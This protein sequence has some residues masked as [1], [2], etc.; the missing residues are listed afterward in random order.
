MKPSPLRKAARFAVIGLIALGILAHY[1]GVSY[2]N[3]IPDGYRYLPPGAK[4]HAFSENIRESWNAASNH[5]GTDRRVVE[6]WVAPLEEEV[7]ADFQEAANEVC[8]FGDGVGLLDE[9]GIETDAGVVFGLFPSEANNLEGTVAVFSL[10]D[11][12]RFLEFLSPLRG[13]PMNLFGA[14]PDEEPIAFMVRVSQGH[15]EA[16]ICS[17]DGSYRISNEYVHIGVDDVALLLYTSAY[18]DVD[19]VIDCKAIYSGGR[20]DDCLCEITDHEEGGCRFASKGRSNKRFNFYGFVSVQQLATEEHPEELQGIEAYIAILE[21]ATVIVATEY[22]LLEGAVSGPRQNLAHYGNDAGLWRTQEVRKRFFPGGTEALAGVWRLSVPFGVGTAAFTVH[23]DESF[24]DLGFLAALDYS[25]PTPVRRL[26]TPFRTE[27]ATVQWPKSSKLGVA[28]ADPYASYLLN[29]WADYLEV[30]MLGG[31]TG[32]EHLVPVLR[33]LGKSEVS[34]ASAHVIG[35]RHGVPMVALGLAV[36]GDEYARTIIRDVQEE[37][38]EARD[39]AVLK[40]AR[41]ATPEIDDNLN[42]D[43]LF[44]ASHIGL[45]AESPEDWDAYR[46]RD[47]EIV[48]VDELSDELFVPELIETVKGRIRVD[49]L[50]PN[51]TANDFMF[52][53][54]GYEFSEEEKSSLKNGTN[55]LLIAYQAH[56]SQK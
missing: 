52:R 53:F 32:L 46:I 20:R 21:D 3:T 29:L 38:K 9:I 4:F 54:D 8:I 18:S 11:R 51:V 23:L 10:A 42:A 55:R 27:P 35:A 31:Q 7:W 39:L 40:A 6:E 15:E 36:G 1:D 17:A 19:I 43:S 48:R 28:V 24:V 56:P 49:Y 16:R 25:Q 14:D 12:N 33:V 37:L 34:A 30:G 45:A 5:V 44:E 26:N 41:Q 47:G 13:K 2:R 50:A 22:G